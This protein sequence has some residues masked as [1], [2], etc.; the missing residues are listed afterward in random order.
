MF[1]PIYCEKCGT[2]LL[3]GMYPYCKGTPDGHG[4]VY[5]KTAGFPFETTHVDGSKMVINDLQ[6]LRKVEKQYGVVFSAFSKSNINDLDPLRDVPRYRPNGRD[7][8]E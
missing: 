2:E 8:E 6:H 4:S 5:A 7:Y 3:V 1:D